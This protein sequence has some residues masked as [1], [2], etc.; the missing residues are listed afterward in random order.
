MIEIDVCQLA[1]GWVATTK[2]G[3]GTVIAAFGFTVFGASNRLQRKIE[4]KWR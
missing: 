1:I 3:D 2:E 4:R